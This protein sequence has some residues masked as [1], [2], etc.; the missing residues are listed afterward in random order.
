MGELAVDL[1][2]FQFA[3]T[4][5][6]HIIFPAFT[7]GLASYLAVLEGLYLKT[8]QQKYIELYQ[9]WIKIFA[10]SFG[11]GVVSGI[12]MS[13][14]FGTNWSVFADK[15][16]PVLGPLLGYEVF[17]AFFLEAGF[18]GVMLFGMNRVGRRLHF[19]ATVIV[20]IGTLLSAFWILSA[21]SW[22][23]TPAGYGMNTQGQFI[24][25]DWWAVVFNPSFPYRLTHM[26]LAAF[27]TT[28]FVVGGVGAYHLLRSQKNHLARTMFS[29]AMWMAAIV[30]P[31]QVIVGDLHGLNTLAHQPAK[32][33]AMEGHFETHEG[34]PL[35]L[36]GLPDQANKTVDYQVSIPYLG[37]LILTHSFTGEV[38]GLDAFPEEDHPPVA[39]V[40]WSFR[41]M[42]ALGFLMLAVGLV[43]LWLRKKKE[44]YHADWFHRCCVVMAPSGF[45]AI[46]CGWITTEVG[47]QPFTVYGL[48]RTADSISPVN[49]AAVSV[50]LAAFVVVYFTVFG[51]GFYYLLRLMRKSPTKY[52]RPLDSDTVTSTTHSNL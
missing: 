9:Y 2:R 32:V 29:M 40:F 21:N 20:A 1:A 27:L 46:L 49:A 18:L 19:M 33:A 45:I 24:P 11:M 42:V 38:K 52:E 8:G 22:M 47:R 16:G 51:A 36:F 25:E 15:T 13:Y 41:I 10:I 14:Q 31:I 26:V 5:S 23:Q 50:S 34:A 35:I 44:L 7:I 4:V 12:V 43:S 28:A 3:F 17:T 48:L 39:I 37:S 30:T 6:F